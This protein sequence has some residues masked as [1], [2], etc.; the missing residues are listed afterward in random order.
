LGVHLPRDAK[1]FESLLDGYRDR[2]L[3]HRAIANAP[4]RRVG[5][6]LV[7]QHVD[8]PRLD[9]GDLLGGQHAIDGW[10]GI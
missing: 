7:E 5:D 6:Q 8:R 1:R 2:A 9:A 10:R 3:V 4:A